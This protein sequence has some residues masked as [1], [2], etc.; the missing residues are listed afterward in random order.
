M[1]AVGLLSGGIDSTLAAKIIADMGIDVFGLNFVTPFCTC[2]KKGCK[3]EAI[4]IAQQLNIKLKIIYASE[5]YIQIIKNPKYGYGKNMNPCL[6][7]RIFMFKKAKLYMEEI[8]ASFIFTGEVLDQRPMSQK[9]SQLKLI[10]RD[11]GLDR[12]ILRPLSAKYLE[13]TIPE[14]KG[15]VDRNRLLSIKGRSR[16]QLKQ[17]AEEQ[18]IEYRCASGGCKLTDPQFAKRIKES[19][20]HNEDS[21]D[22]IYLLR[23]GRHFRLKNN[24]KIVVGRN[25]IENKIIKNIA[26]ENELLFEV[27]DYGSPIAVLKNSISKE[28]IDITASLCARYSDGR[29]IQSV[30]VKVW[31]KNGIEKIIQSRPMDN[32]YMKMVIMI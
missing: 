15:W 21:L 4:Q 7:C 31:S 19:F 28:D 12:L 24:R 18:G 5:E 26:K 2:T 30:N 22:E 16:K 1:K 8:G 17:I 14:E 27:Q 20:E 9:L 29:N 13:L 11:T 23:Y 6:D 32:K 3:N 10:E 25:E